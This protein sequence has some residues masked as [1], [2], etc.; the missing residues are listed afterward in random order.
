MGLCTL[1]HVNIFP[2]EE[3]WGVKVAFVHSEFK[4]HAEIDSESPHRLRNMYFDSA[5]PQKVKGRRRALAR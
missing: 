1:R 2:R 4:L 5:S 3:A